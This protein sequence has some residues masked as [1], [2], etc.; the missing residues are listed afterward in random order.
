MLVKHILH[1]LGSAAVSRE[2]WGVKRD[3]DFQNVVELLA[4]L[5]SVVRSTLLSKVGISGVLV[6]LLL[7]HH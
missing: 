7:G 3:A 4:P 5:G 6:K 2:I 1:H